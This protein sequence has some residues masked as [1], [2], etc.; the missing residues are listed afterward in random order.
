MGSA[1]ISPDHSWLA[2]GTDTEGDEKYVLA[3]RRLV[4]DGL[5]DSAPETVAEIGYGLAWSAD[6]SVVFYTRLDE[7]MRPYQLWRHQLGT[8]PATDVLVYEEADRR[9]SMGTGSTLGRGLRPGLL[10]QHEHHRV[11]GHPS[12]DPTATPRPVGAVF[13]RASNTA[14]TTLFVRRRQRAGSS[15]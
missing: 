15:S 14:S 10:A 7:A 13:A 5:A 3:F 8:D 1:A 9:F 12:G 2:Y 6:A 4:D 11:A